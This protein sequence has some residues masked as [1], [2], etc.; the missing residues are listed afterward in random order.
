[1]NRK[2]IQAFENFNEQ[3][4]KQD[5]SLQLKGRDI[6]LFYLKDDIRARIEY[7]DGRYAVAGTSITFNTS[8]LEAEINNFPER[9]SPN[10]VL[11]PVYQETVL[12][13]VAYIGG[14]AEINYWLQLAS[15]FTHFKTVPP[16]LIL[17]QS[18]WLIRPKQAEWLDSKNITIN[19]L[20]KIRTE[21]DKFDKLNQGNVANPFPE[22][23][24]KF[25]RLKDKTLD[26]A[27]KDGLKHIRE[28]AESWK[29]FEK[30]L[31]ELIKAKNEQLTETGQKEI[32]KLEQLLNNGF[33]GK[34]IQE[35]TVYS[36]EFLIN[37]SDYIKNCMEYLV[38][39]PGSGYFLQL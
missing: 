21:Q 29:H 12:P 5:L 15:V 37:K 25:T 16:A 3:M 17:R 28:T 8:E 22:Q 23:L 9:F 39:K 10:A 31:K 26:M 32:I 6:N 20:F 18:A 38:F 4:A 35:R 19:D 7:K 36:I 24:D 2:S 27:G 11:R 34:S 1:M 33:S 13:N 14:N 30:N